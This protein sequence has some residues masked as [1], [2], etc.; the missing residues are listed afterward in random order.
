MCRWRWIVLRPVASRTNAPTW[1]LP[2]LVMLWALCPISPISLLSILAAPPS[3]DHRRGVFLPP[4]GGAPTKG[5]I[6]SRFFGGRGAGAS[7]P[8]WG[9]FPGELF[10]PPPLP[11]R[12]PRGAGPRGGH[13]TP[14]RM[15]GEPA[16]PTNKIAGPRA[17]SPFEVSAWAGGGGGWGLRLKYAAPPPPLGR[18][19]VLASFSFLGEERKE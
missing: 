2:A 3:L 19:K 16:T 9:F 12:G 10:L 11:L 5:L 6:F 17:P 15:A 8:L 13:R 18:E 14:G 1:H 7:P 4:V